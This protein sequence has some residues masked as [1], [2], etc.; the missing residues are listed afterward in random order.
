MSIDDKYSFIID[1]YP[2]KSIEEILMYSDKARAL[3]SRNEK[4]IAKGSLQI[5][6]AIFMLQGLD[7]HYNSFI[8]NIS[9]IDSKNHTDLLNP[10]KKN[11]I[12]N[13]AHEFIAYLNRLGQ[14][15]KFYKSELF[16]EKCK[17]LEKSKIDKY[18]RM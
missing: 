8:K 9:E 2:K 3:Y 14:F 18:L 10:N 16:K 11:F 1:Y 15:E 7:Y 13:S 5:I 6:G 12:E 4:K 17:Y